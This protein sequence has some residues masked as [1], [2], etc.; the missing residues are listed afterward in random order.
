MLPSQSTK[1]VEIILLNMNSHAH[2]AKS[3]YSLHHCCHTDTLGQGQCFHNLQDK[4][5][6]TYYKRHYA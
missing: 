1:I 4:Q 5:L 6:G 2:V 3:Y